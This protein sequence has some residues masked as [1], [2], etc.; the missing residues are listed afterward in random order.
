MGVPLAA[1]PELCEYDRCLPLCSGAA[2]LLGLTQG[3]PVVTAHPDGAMNQ[4]GDDA[5]EEGIMTL[6]AGTSAALRMVSDRLPY[7]TRRRFGVIMR[8]AAISPERRRPAAPIVLTGLQIRSAG[9]SIHILRLTNW[10][11]KRGARNGKRKICRYFF[12]FYLGSARRAGVNIGREA[13]W[14]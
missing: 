7:R 14:L 4:V 12:L 5:L 11:R 2:A 8:R 9:I 3:I 1:L 13:S 10:R 6:S